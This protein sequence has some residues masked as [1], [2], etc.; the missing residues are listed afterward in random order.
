MTSFLYVLL[1]FTALVGYSTANDWTTWQDANATF[2]GDMNGGETMQGACGYGN[3]FQQGYGLKTAA[4]STALFNN[5]FSCG[6]CYEIRCVDLPRWK[7][8]YKG[9]SPIRITA[10]N[11][12][13]PNPSGGWCNPPARHFD[14]AMPMFLKLAPYKAGIVHVNYRRI[15]CAKSGGVKFRINGNPNFNL[16]FLYNVGG[17]GDVKEVRVRGSKSGGGWI[18]MKKNWGQN[19]ECGNVLVGQTLSFHVVTSDGASRVFKNVVPSSWRFGQ[20]FDG[21]INF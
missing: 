18:P 8:C 10:T 7:W 1:C 17:A 9:A 19:W 5:G 11:Y 21:R 12:C 13:P 14:L 6:A 4:L 3:L 2:Y 20:T 15:R 16:V